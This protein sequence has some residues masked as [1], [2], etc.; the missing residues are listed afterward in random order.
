MHVI[1]DTA[2]LADT[3]ATV[4]LFADEASQQKL[5]KKFNL[6]FFGVTK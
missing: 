3:S 6:R 2:L 4:F 1:A 5:S